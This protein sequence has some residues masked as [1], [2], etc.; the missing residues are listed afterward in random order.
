VN[1]ITDAQDNPIVNQITSKTGINNLYD[2]KYDTYARFWASENSYDLVL[3]LNQPITLEMY[4]FV[5]TSTL[6]VPGNWKLY[7]AESL[8]GG[9]VLL[10]EH[11][12]FPK[13]VISYTEK[14]FSI[15]ASEAYQLYRFVFAKCKFDLSQV[16]FFVR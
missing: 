4:S 12:C 8:D 6:Q 16:H 15:N 11:D 9:W 3:H 7:G 14:A 5:T 10:D 1:G 2:G 13:P